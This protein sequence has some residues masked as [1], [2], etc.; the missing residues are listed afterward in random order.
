MVKL[1]AVYS[2]T[3]L[4]CKGNFITFYHN[5]VKF[6]DCDEFDKCHDLN[7]VQ[8]GNIDMNTTFCVDKGQRVT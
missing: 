3:L 8:I 6:S 1:V 4:E 2:K 5:P 7:F